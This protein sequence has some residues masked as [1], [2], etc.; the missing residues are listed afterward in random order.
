MRDLLYC[1]F[2]DGGLPVR[3]AGA[4][5][6]AGALHSLLRRLRGSGLSMSHRLRFIRHSYD[7]MTERSKEM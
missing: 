2:S 3:F 5:C 4:L 6:L 7:K 1:K